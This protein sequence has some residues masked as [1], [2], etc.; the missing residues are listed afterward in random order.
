MMKRCIAWLCLLPV[1]S[2][3]ETHSGVPGMQTHLGVAQEKMSIGGMETVAN[4]SIGYLDAG[5]STTIRDSSIRELNV[6]GSV[7]IINSSVSHLD[8]GGSIAISDSSVSH[9]DGGGYFT[10]YR[11]SGNTY[12][13]GGKVNMYDSTVNELHVHAE[14]QFQDQYILEARDSSLQSVYIRARGKNPKVFIHNPQ[15][16]VRIVFQDQAGT[17]STNHQAYVSVENGKIASV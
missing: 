7:E 16:S 1:M 9:I 5:G 15:R 10:F 17:V 3:A 4:S 6:G 14:S 12:T 11:T 13:L 2:Q 8:G